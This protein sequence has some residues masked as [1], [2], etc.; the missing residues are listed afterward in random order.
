[1]RSSLRFKP[2]AGA[3]EDFVNHQ[4]RQF[5]SPFHNSHT[6]ILLERIPV[7]RSP[8]NPPNQRNLIHQ[9]FLPLSRPGIYKQEI[10]GQSVNTVWTGA[11]D[12]RNYQLLYC[13]FQTR[14]CVRIS[15]LN[16]LDPLGGLYS[17][18]ECRGTKDSQACGNIPNI[19]IK[20]VPRS[21]NRFHNIL[22]LA[23]RAKYAKLSHAINNTANFLLL[24]WQ[25]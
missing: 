24:V 5:I 13:L 25:G 10:E 1:M 7:L 14:L 9:F 19:T 21:P 18:Q 23:D 22:G 16:T 17:H 20:R 2:L 11:V 6:S 8:C 12:S 3:A 15:I 4:P